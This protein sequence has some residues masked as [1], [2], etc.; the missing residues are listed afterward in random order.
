MYYRLTYHN[1]NTTP[2][3]L[4]SDEKAKLVSSKMLFYTWLLKVGCPRFLWEDIYLAIVYVDDNR[5]EVIM[6]LPAQMPIT[7][8]W[9]SRIIFN[10]EFGVD[11]TLFNRPLDLSNLKFEPLSEVRFFHKLNQSVTPLIRVID[12]VPLETMLTW[13]SQRSDSLTNE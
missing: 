6:A 4:D 9:L 5:I 2:L 13:P 8:S 11:P 1:P 7:V 12:Y 10:N 3:D